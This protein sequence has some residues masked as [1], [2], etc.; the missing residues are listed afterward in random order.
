MSLII[1][2]TCKQHHYASEDR[3]PHCSS[4]VTKATR[5]PSAAAAALL[6]GFS[7]A[8]CDTSSPEP[9]YGF[10]DTGEFEVEDTGGSEEAEA[11]EEE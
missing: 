8:G 6:L 11:E 3:C 2:T 7:I 10:P 5:A 1:C 9:D 4:R